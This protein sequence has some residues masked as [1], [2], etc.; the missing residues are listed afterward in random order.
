[1]KKYFC[2]NRLSRGKLTR[3]GALVFWQGLMICIR[4]VAFLGRRLKT[5]LQ[6]EVHIFLLILYPPADFTFYT[7]LRQNMVVKLNYYVP[8]GSCTFPVSFRYKAQMVIAGPPMITKINPRLK[9]MRMMSTIQSRKVYS[10]F[11]SLPHG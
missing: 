4:N 11:S 2:A 7:Y 3:Q 9:G 1:M 10:I 5:G 6:E 8:E